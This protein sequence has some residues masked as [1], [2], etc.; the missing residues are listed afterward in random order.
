MGGLCWELSRLPYLVPENHER[1][2]RLVDLRQ[3]PVSISIELIDKK[4][5]GYHS[6]FVRR[7]QTKSLLFLRQVLHIN[8]NL[9]RTDLP[10]IL[11]TAKPRNTVHNFNW[12]WLNSPRININLAGFV[13]LRRSTGAPQH[14]DKLRRRYDHL[15]L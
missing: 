11:S 9:E 8:A 3:L 1:S 5:N 14:E 13:E 12:F 4:P 2:R 15:L 10:I 6:L 7:V